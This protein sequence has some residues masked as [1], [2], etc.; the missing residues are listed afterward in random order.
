LAQNGRQTLIHYPI[1]P[2]RQ[3]AL[4]RFAHLYL[5]ITDRIHES[6]FSIPL[7]PYLPDNEIDEVISILIKVNLK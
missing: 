7:N 6:I 1:A 2:H 4:S 3:L 5:P